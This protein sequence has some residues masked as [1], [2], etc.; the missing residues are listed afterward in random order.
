MLVI[1][2]QVALYVAACDAMHVETP[3][4]RVLH[5]EE[6]FTTR[7]I[8]ILW[9]NTHTQSYIYVHVCVRP[10]TWLEQVGPMGSVGPPRVFGMYRASFDGTICSATISVSHVNFNANVL[11]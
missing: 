4:R 3:T 11:H 5:F 7:L 6:S 1:H 2:E 10:F 8:G 9:A